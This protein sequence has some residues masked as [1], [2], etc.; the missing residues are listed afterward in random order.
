[1][2]Q[3][4]SF[5]ITPTRRLRENFCLART[6]WDAIVS[7]GCCTAAGCRWMALI[8]LPP[9]AEFAPRSCGAILADGAGLSSDGGK[10]GHP[11]PRHQRADA[12]VGQHSCRASELS[13]DS[14][15]AMDLDTRNS[16][17]YGGGELAF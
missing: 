1:M 7:R 3:P 5:A 2:T 9:A 17:S 14:R 8:V 12:V 13:T 6:S 4:H 16:V 15:S 10:P 11:W